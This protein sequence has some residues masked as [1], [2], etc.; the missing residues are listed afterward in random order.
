[1]TKKDFENFD[2]SCV[3][4]LIHS[5]MDRKSTILEIPYARAVALTWYGSRSGR[6]NVVK[7]SL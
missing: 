1:M 5:H 6:P 2:F 7:E 4:K 3:Q